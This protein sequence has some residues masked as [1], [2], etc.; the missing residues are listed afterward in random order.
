MYNDL[1]FISVK[2]YQ[3]YVDLGPQKFLSFSLF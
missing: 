3:Y 2:V 1:K